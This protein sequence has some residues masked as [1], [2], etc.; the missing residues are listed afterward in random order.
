ME[1]VE[2]KVNE[3]IGDIRFAI[4]D[5]PRK[6]TLEKKIDYLEDVFSAAINYIYAE[7]DNLKDLKK[8]LEGEE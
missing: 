5:H 3:F 4:I 6:K 8:K 2:N 1:E 7:D